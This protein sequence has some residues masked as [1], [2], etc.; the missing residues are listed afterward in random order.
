MIGF[1]VILDKRDLQF[2]RLML[3]AVPRGFDRAAR[4]AIN[5]TVS[6]ARKI[7]IGAVREERPGMKVK[8]VRR[9]VTGVKSG[10]RL[11]GAVVISPR[12]PPLIEMNPNP[13]TPERDLARAR[14]RGVSYKS[15]KGGRTR[16][17]DAFVA[18]MGSGHVGVF[19]R[20]GPD[21]TPMVEPKGP[22]SAEVL[23][24]APG[25]QARAETEIATHLRNE[26]G[27]QVDRMLRRAG[28]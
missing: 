2:A 21:R 10:R 16:I 28:R 7:I 1:N 14:R 13:K 17:K 25:V 9:G 26:L 24:D 18:R 4:F 8:T 5:K 11:V 3:R 12:R 15:A 23:K 6:R 22:S 27:N 20:V 19:K